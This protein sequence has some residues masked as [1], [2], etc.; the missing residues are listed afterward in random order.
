MQIMLT[1]LPLSISL[2]I[3]IY[4]CILRPE[5]RPEHDAL[6]AVQA[7][8]FLFRLN[9]LLISYCFISIVII[10]IIISSSSSSMSSS[11]SLS[12]SIYIY[13]YIYTCLRSGIGQ[14]TV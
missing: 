12:L 6:A 1:S 9:D 13:I 4:I 7:P 2:Y 8:R 11:L 3:Y 5:V 10:V 14:I